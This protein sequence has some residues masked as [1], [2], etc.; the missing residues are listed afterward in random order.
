M[1]PRRAAVLVSIVS[2][3]VTALATAAPRGP[4][5]PRDPE[6]ADKARLSAV[7]DAQAGGVQTCAV[8]HAI[9]RGATDVTVTATLL[10]DP[11]G[12]PM[13]IVVEVKADK[14]DAAPV[15]QCVEK[16]LAA[17]RFPA[18]SSR[19]NMSQIW[20]SWSFATEPAPARQR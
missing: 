20:R 9:A 7:L 16:L 11:R 5:K 8:D 19:T 14:V 4:K 15:R 13:S 12:M 1:M 10:I 17:V 18:S 6:A 2:L 3:A